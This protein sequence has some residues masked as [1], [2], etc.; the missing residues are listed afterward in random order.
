MTSRRAVLVRSWGLALAA[1]LSLAP[2][3]GAD[4]EPPPAPVAS[5]GQSAS[6]DGDTSGSDGAATGDATAS[7]STTGASDETA[8]DPSEDPLDG[9]GPV[10]LV[11]DGFSRL[12]GP[13]WRAEPGDLLF[14]D[15]ATDTIHRL[16][17][18][19]AVDV[20]R[21]P[22]APPT[23]ANGLALDGGGRLVACEHA[24]Q[25]VTRGDLG[26]E[27]VAN[28]W[29]GMPLNSPNDLV[30]H[31]SGGVL[32]TD[33]TYGSLPELGGATP[34]LG[35]QG[36]YLA[37][38]GG[39]LE[40]VYGGFVQPNGIALSPAHDLL[41]VADTEQGAVLTFPLDATGRP[42]SDTPSLVT[43]QA[44]GADGLEIDAAGNLYVAT[45]AGILVLDPDGVAWG[46]IELPETPSNLEFGGPELRTLYVTATTG[47]YRVELAV[48]GLP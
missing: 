22:T 47:L 45:T 28:L 18:P 38:T 16:V 30:V 24:T 39:G 5:A 7:A 29:M 31:P 9:I 10:E 14:T 2:G 4:D 1:V 13:V 41:Y 42:T 26:E 32:F 34:V 23:H 6:G 43:D 36:V 15:V 12:E 20:F 35:F 17:P 40:L 8:A 3:C 48:A 21:G 25:R 46:G 44:A 19:D 11:A 33:P 27:I 37:P